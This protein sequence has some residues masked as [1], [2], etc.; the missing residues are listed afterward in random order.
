VPG[1]LLPGRGELGSY[2]AS[3]SGL[4]AYGQALQVA[5]LMVSVAASG[6]GA[7][8]YAGRAVDWRAGMAIIARCVRCARCSFS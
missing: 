5:E 4:A 2:S 8:R 7:W 6:R 3:V 1:R